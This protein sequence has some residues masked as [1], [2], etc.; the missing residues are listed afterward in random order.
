MTPTADTILETILRLSETDRGE[1][2]AR[3]LDSLEPETDADADAAWDEEIRT[4]VEDV[5]AGRVKTV[6][7]AEARTQILA[8]GDGTS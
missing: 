1:L 6:S 5:R 7:W 4:R 2:A 8:D 3:L